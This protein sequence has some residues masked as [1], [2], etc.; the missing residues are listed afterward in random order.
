[1]SRKYGT[2]LAVVRSVPIKISMFVM[3]FLSHAGNRTAIPRSRCPDYNNYCFFSAHQRYDMSNGTLVLND[4]KIEAVF[5]GSIPLPPGGT[6]SMPSVYHERYVIARF[7]W[8]PCVKMPE[9][10][11]FS[12]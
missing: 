7:C 1:M 11:L 8:L 12:G 3:F 9:V 6:T 4:P 10:C 5:L 2:K